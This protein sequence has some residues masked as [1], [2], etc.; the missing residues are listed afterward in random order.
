MESMFVDMLFRRTIFFLRNGSHMH[1]QRCLTLAPV[2]PRCQG[3]LL[4]LCTVL[5]HFNSRFIYVSP[6]LI[7]DTSALA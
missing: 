2:A 7:S 1:L 5:P 3:T 6:K 4:I